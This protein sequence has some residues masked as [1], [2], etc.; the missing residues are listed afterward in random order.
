MIET[1]VA[2][3]KL[4][5][6][7]VPAVGEA[8][9][10]P[11]VAAE[12]GLNAAAV[13]GAE[14]TAISGGAE[15]AAS[16]ATKLAPEDTIANVAEQALNTGQAPEGIAEVAGQ[17]PSPNALA[18][19]VNTPPTEGPKPPELK[20]DYANPPDATGQPAAQTPE[21]AAP[22]P[23][24]ETPTTTDD[25]TPP[26]TSDA[27]ARSYPEF[28]PSVPSDEEKKLTDRLAKGET[29]SGE[30][31]DKLSALRAQ[32]FE[33]GRMDDI[34]ERLQNNKPVTPEEIRQLNEFNANKTAEAAKPQT[35]EQ[36]KLEKKKAFETYAESIVQKLARGEAPTEDELKKLQTDSDEITGKSRTVSDKAAENLVQMMLNPDQMLTSGKSAQ[37]IA[38]AQE[39]LANLQ[40]LASLEMQLLLIPKKLDTLRSK[41]KQL[42]ADIH[43]AENMEKQQGKNPEGRIKK[44]NLMG[45]LTNVKAE[46]VK[47]LYLSVVYQA[48]YKTIMAD[49]RSKLGLTKGFSALMEHMSA[50]ISRLYAKFRLRFASLSE[51]DNAL[52]DLEGAINTDFSI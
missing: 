41:G 15:V 14:T 20:D 40:R 44:Y 2:G 51:A 26:K 19:E 12:G 38:E 46:T 35:P 34:K 9:A 37:E 52:A 8:A 18:P 47:T 17:A 27:E 39:V 33:A 10:M 23:A 7:E 42:I 1:A 48:E 29:L 32:R 31:A 13:A 36:I 45:E 28:T 25:K 4:A 50:M 6:V 24:P 22:G 43:E 30:E 11:V 5:G 21:G 16:V 49:A 3:A